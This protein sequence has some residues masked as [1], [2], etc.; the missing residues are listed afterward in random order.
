LVTEGQ[1]LDLA[2]TGTRSVTVGA[3]LDMIARKSAALIA[4]AAAM[5]AEVAQAAPETVDAAQSFGHALGLGFQIRDDVLGMWGVPE[6]TGKPTSDLARR[7]KTLP[8]L[9]ALGRVPD[10]DRRAIH[11]LFESTDASPAVLEAAQAA[12]DRSGARRHCET[13][14]A[15]Y[16]LEARTHLNALPAGDSRDALG[17]LVAMLEL[18][19]V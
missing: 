5:G 13:L 8:T 14:V 11:A 15:R 17:E 4:C 3:Y 2:F 6:M 19:D 10:A 9:Y 18:R 12:I 7:K 1:H 16:S